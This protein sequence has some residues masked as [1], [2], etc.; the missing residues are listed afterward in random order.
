[1]KT[2]A[3]TSQLCGGKA[4]AVVAP[5]LTNSKRRIRDA[6]CSMKDQQYP[7]GTDWVGEF[8][9]LSSRLLELVNSNAKSAK[10]KNTL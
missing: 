8:G 4:L 5:A 10:K 9:I 6:I 2:A 3:V 7:F 1:M